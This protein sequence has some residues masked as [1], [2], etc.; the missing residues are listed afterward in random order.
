MS[1]S[2]LAQ[3]I[4]A[5]F[6]PEL[7]RFLLPF[8][9][10]SLRSKDTV[11]RA[12]KRNE[13]PFDQET[14]DRWFSATTR[15]DTQLELIHAGLE[16]RPECKP[17]FQQI[18]QDLFGV[19]RIY[20]HYKPAQTLREAPYATHIQQATLD[21][22]VRLLGGLPS[23]GLEVGSYVG[24]GACQLGQLC[25]QNQGVL[26]CVDTWCGDVNMWLGDAFASTMGKQDGN[27]D[28]YS[29]HPP[30]RGA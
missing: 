4:K 27:P 30:D 19:D 22:L 25:K 7:R 23:L 9:P 29:F 10:K 13:N 1:E 24:H 17:S 16:A 8:V 14:V 2:S 28:L 11:I 3:R 21:R 12:A 5:A 20:H 15:M 18:S 6:P 26:L